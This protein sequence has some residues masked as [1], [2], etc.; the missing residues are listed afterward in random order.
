VPTIVITAAGGLAALLAFGVADQGASTSIDAALA[1]GVRPVAPTSRTVL[2][3]LGSDSSESLENFRGKVVVRNV[4]ASWCDPHKAEAPILEQEPRRLV[5]TRR[6]SASRTSTTRTIRSSSPARSSY[7]RPPTK[8]RRGGSGASS[9]GDHCRPVKRP[10]R[11]PRFP[12]RVIPASGPDRTDGVAAM[13]TP[14]ERFPRKR[15]SGYR[16]HSATPGL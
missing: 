14:D 3:E 7:C 6:S 15:S 12:C 10:R 16:Q 13:A 4:F 5:R 1:N 9:R 11:S 2:P 8:R